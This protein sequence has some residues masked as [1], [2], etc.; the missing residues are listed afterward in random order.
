MIGVMETHLVTDWTRRHA[1]TQL[2][3]A[4]FSLAMTALILASVAFWADWS[5]P[6]LVVAATGC[7]LMNLWIVWWAVRNA[8]DMRR[9][10]VRATD[11]ALVVDGFKARSRIPWADIERFEIGPS[12][13]R[14]ATTTQLSIYAVLHIGGRVELEALRVDGIVTPRATKQA[15]LEPYR[16]ALERFVA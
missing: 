9:I 1:T 2:G 16:A 4:A 8:R 13:E 5:P 3:V 10:H 15:T 6:A 14:L 7:V 12:S 11:D